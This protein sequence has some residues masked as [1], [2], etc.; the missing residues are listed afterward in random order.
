MFLLRFLLACVLLAAVPACADATEPA[1][2]RGLNLSSWL[3]NAPRQPLFARDFAQIKRVGFD[4]VRL[5]FNPGYYGFRFSPQGGNAAQ[6]DFVALDRAVALAEQYDLPVIIDI[7]PGE[8]FMDTLQ[9]NAWAEDEFVDLWKTI[10]AHYKDHASSAVIFELLNEP[11][12]Y[13][14]EEQ[15][16][17]LS[18]R[19]IEA[20]RAVS[21]Q[22]III[23]DAPHGADIEALSFLHPVSDPRIIY[24]FHFYEPYVI[25][26]QGIHQGFA[27]KAIRYLR[28]LPY[29]ST[30]ATK[31]PASYAPDAPDPAEAAREIQD[32]IDTPW[33]AAHVAARIAL[34]Q[35][36]ATEHR[37]RVICGEFG[38]LRNHIDPAS[39][40]R[41]IAD[42]RAAMDAD[43]IGWELWDYADLFGIAP[44]TNPTAP[45]P[46]DGSV[47]M[48]DPQN[49]ERVF[50]PQALRALGL[51]EKP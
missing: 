43:G 39:R 30:L 7:H 46:V 35:R 19:L 42:A 49:G 25:T 48:Q 18:T 40:Y 26:H 33:N 15:W 13:K 24:A 28:G 3:A 44:P 36:W 47:R 1:L 2:H 37:T 10:A 12:Y 4:H 23:V 27:G 8:D 14:W 51:D 6:V 20:I 31:P 17:R 9:N 21:P 41:W 22:R 38:V 16:N 5:P 32:Y 11:Q 50:E 45:D 34:A 29:P